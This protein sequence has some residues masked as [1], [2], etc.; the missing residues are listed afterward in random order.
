MEIRQVNTIE[1]YDACVH[2]QRAVFG[3]PDLEISPRRHLIVTD[4]SRR[5]DSRCVCG[6]KARR[7]CSSSA[8]GA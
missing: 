1:E 5:L 4:A 2:L 7:V 6:R 8:G 3:L